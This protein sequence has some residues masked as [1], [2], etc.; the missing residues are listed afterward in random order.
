MEKDTPRSSY[1]LSHVRWYLSRSRRYTLSMRHDFRRI[2]CPINQKTLT[3]KFFNL[4]IIKILLDISLKDK[5]TQATLLSFNEY[6][7]RNTVAR[8]TEILVAKSD[9]F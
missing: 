4:Y 6:D 2:L 9:L 1:S 5:D 3:N 7:A 8:H